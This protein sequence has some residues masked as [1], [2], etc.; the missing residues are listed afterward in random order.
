MSLSKPAVPF[1]LPLAAAV[2]SALLQTALPAQADEILLIERS[3][4]RAGRDR[5]VRLFRQKRIDI[6]ADGMPAAELA[7]LLRIAADDKLNFIVQTKGTVEPDWPALVVDL[8]RHPMLSA[9]AVVESA[10]DLRFVYRDGLVLL[11]PKDEVKELRV[12]HIYDLRAAVAPLRDHPGP[13]LG[14]TPRGTDFVEPEPEDTG[15]TLSGWTL[16]QVQDLV[17]THVDPDSWDA[18]GV[19]MAESQQGALLIRQTEQ[20]HRKIQDLLETLGVWQRP[21][22]VVL[23]AATPA[24]TEQPAPQA[25]HG[26]TSAAEEKKKAS[27]DREKPG[28]GSK[29]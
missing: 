20:N 8:R 4:D 15:K 16:E 5:A 6:R 22:V 2:L 12:L 24:G 17:R 28:D 10:T 18:E 26:K 11:K 25:G 3:Q 1:V 27:K 14:L 23:P 29:R 7:G 19:S 21:R 13:T 9:M